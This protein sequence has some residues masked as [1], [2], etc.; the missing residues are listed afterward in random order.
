MLYC[1]RVVRIEPF[2]VSKSYHIVLLTSEH[3]SYK[4]LGHGT[5]TI[6]FA[7]G[8]ALVDGLSDGLLMGGPY[9]VLRA[10]PYYC[11]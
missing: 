6:S 11:G 10:G 4:P 3:C 2:T 8:I 7:D 1:I 9:R 5:D